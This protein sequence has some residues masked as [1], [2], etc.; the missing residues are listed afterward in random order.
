MLVLEPVHQLHCD[1]SS[2]VAL[3]CRTCSGSRRCSNLPHDWRLRLNLSVSESHHTQIWASY[4]EAGLQEILNASLNAC[5]QAR[6]SSLITACLVPF[7]EDSA[8]SLSSC[9]RSCASTSSTG[10]RRS[11]SGLSAWKPCERAS[12]R[13]LCYASDIMS[14][15]CA[16]T[17]ICNRLSHA[18]AAMTPASAK[19]LT[20]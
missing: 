17:S 7:K 12:K 8:S 10:A 6:T 20:C 9:G 14:R 2:C 15:S 16:S 5:L 1:F 3:Y 13:Y 19:K 4:D 11:T 18:S